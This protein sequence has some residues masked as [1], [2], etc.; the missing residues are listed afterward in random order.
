M[1]QCWYIYNIDKGVILEFSIGSEIQHWFFGPEPTIFLDKLRRGNG[2]IS[3]S[4]AGDRITCMGDYTKINDLPKNLFTEEELVAL[5][6]FKKHK[7]VGNSGCGFWKLK[8]GE[9]DASLRESLDK[10]YETVYFEWDHPDEDWHV[11]YVLRNLSKKVYIRGDGAAKGSDGQSLFGQMLLF[12]I[13]W[14]SDPHAMICQRTNSPDILR[15]LWAGDRFDL[16]LFDNVKQEL[17]KKWKDVTKEVKD[18]VIGIFE[19]N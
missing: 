5:G 16:V 18:H 15:G 1:G 7:D 14:S 2:D 10:S 3:E 17:D 6:Y 11:K 12:Y 9:H 13:C 8:S 4:W 19:E